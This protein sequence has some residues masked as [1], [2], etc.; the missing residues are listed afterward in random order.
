MY[1]MSEMQQKK[2][3]PPLDLLQFYGRSHITLYLGGDPL[4]DVKPSL[5]HW[6]NDKISNIW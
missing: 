1:N 6:N 2:D 4:K 5:D 3:S